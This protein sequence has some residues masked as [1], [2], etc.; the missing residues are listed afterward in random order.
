MAS[1]QVWWVH[2]SVEVCSQQVFDG[3]T[4]NQVCGLGVLLGIVLFM[5]VTSVAG[6][7][8]YQFGFIH[9]LQPCLEK[10]ELAPVTH[11]LV[12]S[13]LNY[14]SDLHIGLPLETVQK[15][16]LLQTSA[17]RMLVGVD[18]LITSH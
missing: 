17:A 15:L 13:R 9:Q 2:I 14:Y 1:I 3:V 4:Q 8:F 16:Q 18:R 7:D 5:D 10:V 6:S 12:T 11:A